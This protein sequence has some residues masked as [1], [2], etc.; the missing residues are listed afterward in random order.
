MKPRIKY[1]TIAVVLL[2][3]LSGFG[4]IAV[5]DARLGRN[6]E[7]LL[8][9]FREL[10]LNYVD[11]VDSDQLLRDAAEGMAS[12][13]DPYTELITNDRMSEL[14]LMTTGKYGGI[15]ALI[16]A[17][18]NYVCIAEP[19]KGFPADKAG[20]RSGD[21]ILRIDGEDMRGATTQSVSNKLKGDPGTTFR[22]TIRESATGNERELSIK[23]ERIAIPSISYFGMVG[24]SIGYIHHG[25]FTDGCFAQ[26]RKAVETLQEQGAKSLILDYRSNGGGV[27]QEAVKIMSLFVPAQTEIVSMKGRDEASKRVLST[28]SDPIAL[29]MPL[30]VLVDGYTASSAEILT[31]A[32]Q[33]LDRGVVLGQRTFGKGLVQSTL[34]LPYDSYL[35]IT[36]AK[37]YTPSGRCIQ[38]FDYSK[39]GHQGGNHIADSLISEFT[40]A[41]GRKVYD[42]GGITPDVVTKPMAVSQYA[43]MIYGLGLVDN[44]ADHY[45]R[46]HTLD[47]D[48]LA[49]FSITDADYD[50]FVSIVGE[51]KLDFEIETLKALKILAD[52]A[53]DEGYSELATELKGLEDKLPV[54][55][56]SMLNLHKTQITELINEAVVLRVAY[57]A[58]LERYRIAY[59]DEVKQAVEI[60]SNPETYNSI[61]T[62]AA[63]E[64]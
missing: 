1:I 21:A 63:K 54:D 23:R 16:R 58:G 20:L 4:S 64:K 42:G 39:R 22:L 61:L 56:A 35:K 45:V 60:L 11:E 18:S 26:M 43:S 30:V 37:Y 53:T 34:P 38:S 50:E 36:T 29:T 2:V 14:D 52:V 17:D 62:S 7:V 55:N 33:D 19:Y 24:D 57:R 15:G 59:D 9:M 32:I 3:A 48:S 25:D 41:Q 13:L 27:V 10:S 6:V 49:G 46:N 5:R 47:A 31:G 44:Y 51:R 28:T 8:A 40:T 12:S